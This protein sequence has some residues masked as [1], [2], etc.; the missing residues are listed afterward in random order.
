MRR[1]TDFTE[2]DIEEWFKAFSSV[3]ICMFLFI[4][5]L[6]KTSLTS[7]IIQECPK[8]VLTRSKM[9]NIYED[10]GTVLSPEILVDNL[11]KIFDK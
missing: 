8:G 11:L 2:S 9:I 10:L 5:E 6:C 4:L 1:Q 3:R 7:F